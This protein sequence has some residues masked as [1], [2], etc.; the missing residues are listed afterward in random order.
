[1]AAYSALQCRAQASERTLRGVVR[2]RNRL[3]S[4]FGAVVSAP[5]GVVA[6][7]P[8]VL[9]GAGDVGAMVDGGVAGA[10]V[11]GGVVLAAGVS[12]FLSQAVRATASKAATSRVLVIISSS[13]L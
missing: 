6:A 12:A 10:M 7:P 3:T 5:P 8:I 1:V 11:D 4:Y 13:S 9:P 2:T